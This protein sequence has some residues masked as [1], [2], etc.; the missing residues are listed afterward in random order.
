MTDDLRLLA[1]DCR[2]A[3]FDAIK[4]DGGA[5]NATRFEVGR[6][7]GLLSRMSAAPTP[8]SDDVTEDHAP[9]DADFEM[10]ARFYASRSFGDSKENEML[11]LRR[12]QAE[13]RIDALVY[14]FMQHRLASASRPGG[15]LVG[16]LEIGEKFLNK[17]F[18]AWATGEPAH[19][20]AD[21]LD[22]ADKF[23]AALNALS[24]AQG[25]K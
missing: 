11:R 4:A 19:R 15:D 7:I 21:M 16:A 10:A 1:A 8:A 18:S 24:D 14:L 6:A 25:R 17:C 12:A 13:D 2:Q 20:V 5:S 23:R 9:I 3:L 22:H